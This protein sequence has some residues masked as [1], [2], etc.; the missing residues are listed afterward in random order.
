MLKEEFE[1]L[2]HGK[3]EIKD[4]HKIESVYC[5]YDMFSTKQKIADEFI[6]NGMVKI[7]YLYRLIAK[8]YHAVPY[9]TR[10]YTKLDAVEQSGHAD[11]Y[12]TFYLDEA[13]ANKRL[14]DKLDKIKEVIYQ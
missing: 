14:R 12:R 6:G 11:S 10:K 4:Y 13:D 3:V 8:K 7:D 5:E 2:I 9:K 1:K